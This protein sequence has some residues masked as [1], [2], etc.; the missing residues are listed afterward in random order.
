MVQHGR[1][2][3]VTTAKNV[4]EVVDGIERLI[5]NPA[6]RREMAVHARSYAERQSW[7]KIYLNFWNGE[8]SGFGCRVCCV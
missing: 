3:I 8:K 7:E 1:T 4:N 2:G 5:D 6:A